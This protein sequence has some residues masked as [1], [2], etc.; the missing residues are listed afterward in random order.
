MANKQTTP[1]KK[2]R[3][4]ERHKHRSHCGI[5]QLKL[6]LHRVGYILHGSLC[7]Y[8]GEYQLIPEGHIYLLRAGVHKVEYISD[9]GSHYE[10]IVV[11]LSHN[12][13]RTII[14]NMQLSFGIRVRKS[15]AIT[16]KQYAYDKA[17]KMTTHLFKGLKE[18][19]KEDIFDRCGAMERMKTNEIVYLLLCQSNSNVA[20][21]LQQLLKSSRVDFEEHI[22]ASTFRNITIERLAREC[23]MSP[24]S[25]KLTFERY[26]GCPPHKWFVTRRLSAVTM[27]LLHTREPIKKIAGECGFASSSHLIRLFRT[28]YGT[29]PALYRA[30]HAHNPPKNIIKNE[31]LVIK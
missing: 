6:E 21:A 18:Y 9:G 26:F 12:L 14:C 31:N 5:R 1:R 27:L 25:F 29:T 24:S 30:A 2:R 7:I 16:T 17:T 22:Y 10:E 8:D 19:L 28:N 11:G 13:A 20:I 4:I 3:Y 23:N 15:G